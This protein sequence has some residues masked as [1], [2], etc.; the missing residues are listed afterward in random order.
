M[1]ARK[2]RPNFGRLGDHAPETEAEPVAKSASKHDEIAIKPHVG[3][4][5]T[6]VEPA[7]IH[8]VF[9]SGDG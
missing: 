5:R 8:E 7:P 2:R 9:H 6:T 3:R 4:S 1:T